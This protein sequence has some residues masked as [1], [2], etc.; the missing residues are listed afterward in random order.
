[1]STGA[2]PQAIEDDAVGAAGLPIAWAATRFGEYVGWGPTPEMAAR[3]AALLGMTRCEVEPVPWDAY[4]FILRGLSHRCWRTE[5]ELL[6]ALLVSALENLDPDSYPLDHVDE[7]A[8]HR[9]IDALETALAEL[10]H[11]PPLSLPLT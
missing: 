9:R 3:S 11:P 8:V 2:L 5:R 7:D 6:E 1:M 4:E 10:D